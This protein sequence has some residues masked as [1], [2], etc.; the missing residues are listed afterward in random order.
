MHTSIPEPAAWFCK[1]SLERWLPLR[2]QQNCYGDGL[3]I[4]SAKKSQTIQRNHKALRNHPCR[5]ASFT[6]KAIFKEGMA[7]SMDTPAEERPE[8][9]SRNAMSSSRKGWAGVGG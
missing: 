6:L 5:N 1:Q 9:A 7:C 2:L 3:R 4:F 8:T